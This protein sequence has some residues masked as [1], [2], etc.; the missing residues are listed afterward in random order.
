MTSVPKAIIERCQSLKEGVVIAPKEFLHLGS[1]AAVDQAFSRLVKA[2]RLMRVARGTYVSPVFDDLGNRAP[3]LDSVADS[4]SAQGKQAITLDGSRAASLLGLTI[5]ASTQQV[6][7]TSGRSKRLV[8]GDQVVL[9][10]HAPYWQL[11]LGSTP[12]GNAVRALAYLGKE[13][14]YDVAKQLRNQLPRREWDALTSV[15]ASVPSWMASALG[16]AS[17]LPVLH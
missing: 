4:I 16:K 7:L 10:Q 2:G 17:A 9:L 8:V 3:S 15:R 14:A 11:A 5:G 13:R 1:R 6:Y 12:A